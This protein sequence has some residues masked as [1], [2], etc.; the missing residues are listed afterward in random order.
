MNKINTS[1]AGQKGF[2][3]VELLVVIVVIGILA[4]ITVVV[5]N[6]V[7]KKAAVSV[8]QNSLSNAAKA[9]KAQAA[10]TGSF[11]IAFPSN[12]QVS[13]GVGIAL[14]QTSDNAANFCINGVYA[15]DASIQFHA[16]QVQNVI[17]GL[18]EGEVIEA[19]IV[20]EYVSGE[21]A[22]RSYAGVAIGTGG[23]FEVRTDDNWNG[24]KIKWDAVSNAT[25]YEV[26]YRTAP[27]NPWYWI[28]KDTGAGTT[29]SGSNTTSSIASNVTS[30]DWATSTAKPTS[31][32]QVNE[33]RY[34]S[35][36]GGVA[37]AWYT[38][39]LSPPNGNDLPALKKL[40]VAA[41]G[42]WTG[43]GISW[44]GNVSTV[45][46]LYYEV[47]YRTGSANPWY[48]IRKDTGAGTT[49][50]D[51]SS[52]TSSIPAATTSYT[53][54]SG[55]AKPSSAG[56]AYD[57]RIRAASST[58]YGLY[59]P[60][61]NATLTPP[62]NSSYPVP[63]TL[64]FTQINSWAGFSLA[65]TGDVSAVPSYYYEIQYR[66]DT[67]TAPWY[68]IRKSD[69]AGNSSTSGTTSNVAA[70]INS[71]EWATGSAKPSAGTSYQ[72]RIRAVSSVIQN[73]YSDWRTITVTR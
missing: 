71:Y 19:S 55:N 17:E 20:G 58:I 53:W 51:A 12:V 52:T 67:T 68:W 7:Q 38:A 62:T 2:T 70:G 41:N 34:R 49:S 6:G 10:E 28:R 54:A 56:E 46:G 36:V 31:F 24:L 40:N 42:S 39:S 32:D 22:P 35:T 23:G 21:A 9:M 11:G 5:F 15:K 1:R 30:I 48:W 43:M 8:V 27:A 64:V 3:I 73:S 50:S 13:T 65:W 60:W 18:C 4:A 33:Y 29:S 26:Q 61:T 72:Y 37:G 45:P 44:T 66:T 25:A 57:Y 59:G 16:T 47:Q 63:A 14:T 69:G